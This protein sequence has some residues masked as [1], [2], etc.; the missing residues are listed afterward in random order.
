MA[1][2]KAPMYVKDLYRILKAYIKNDNES[3]YDFIYNR[4]GIVE[5]W[6]TI[7]QV[8]IIV[9]DSANIKSSSFMSR[10]FEFEEEI[11]GLSED[12]PKEEKIVR[13]EVK[14]FISFLE[15]N[16]RGLA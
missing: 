12:E 2:L 1:K 16:Y 15:A 11:E 3:V 5:T 7:Y 14:K 10:L 9:L 4:D 6:R 13:K 8:L